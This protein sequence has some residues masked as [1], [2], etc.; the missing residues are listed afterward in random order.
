MIETILNYCLSDRDY[1]KLY[2]RMIE[3]IGHYCTSDRDQNKLDTNDR[4]HWTLWHEWSRPKQNIDTND[5]DYWT[6]WH[7]WSI[8]KQTNILIYMMLIC[9]VDLMNIECKMIDC[10]LLKYS[11]GNVVLEFIICYMVPW[12]ACMLHTTLHPGV[13]PY[14]W[15]FAFYCGRFAF[16]IRRFLW[17]A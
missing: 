15:S 9:V 6:L 4:D 11:I 3:T 2:I 16:K 14:S 17:I 13:V 10:Y 1:N 5:R 7:E 12:T 8:P